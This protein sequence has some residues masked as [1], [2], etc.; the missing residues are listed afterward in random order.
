VRDKNGVEWSV[1][2]TTRG[3]IFYDNAGRQGIPFGQTIPV[4]VGSDVEN[5]YNMSYYGSQG[6]AQ[7]RAAGEGFAPGPTQTAPGMP[8]GQAPGVVAT[9]PNGARVTAEQQD[10]ASR[11]FPVISGVRTKEENDALKYRQ[12]SN[13]SWVTK[14]GNP[15]SDS[16]IHA[17]GS[18]MDIDA[19]KLTTAQRRELSQNGW[20]QPIPQQDPNHWEKLPGATAPQAAP[21]QGPAPSS[22][23]N[24]PSAGYGPSNVPG[25]APQGTVAQ[26]RQQLEIGGKRTEAFNK[27][28]DTE[29]RETAA[30]GEIVS[31]NRKKQFEIL[32]R[33]DPDTNKGVAEQISGLAT[34][35]NEGPGAQKFT[36]IRDLI[37]GKVVTNSNGTPMNAEQLSE[38][39]RQLG[40]SSAVKGALQEFNALNAQIAAQTLKETAG[41]GSVSDAEQQ[42]NRARNV[43]I[44]KTPMLGAYNMMSQSQFSGD[45]QRYKADLAASDNNRAPNATAFDRDFRKT[46]AALSDSYKKV[47]E[48]RLDFINKNGGANNPNAI[49]VGYK[50]FPVPEY[51]PQSGNWKYLKPL[52][53]IFGKQ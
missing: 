17:V 31:A 16:S 3:S 28:I 34:A 29:Y 2:P 25:G 50:R 5:K 39:L 18:A 45:L 52:T 32:N 43:D 24:I 21:G 42:A 30:K 13:G 27:I 41:P 53:D 11:G 48:A 26:Q 36:I 49:R 22:N 15:V 38:R 33:V 4:A 6:T 37:A 10:Y 51:D 12:L 47:T 40:L 8:G 46:S 19:K 1:V 44:T 20:Y 23:P 9:L 14:E 35:A 7:G